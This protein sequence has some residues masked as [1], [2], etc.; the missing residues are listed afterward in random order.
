MK[1]WIADQFPTDKPAFLFDEIERDSR[2]EVSIEAF[3]ALQADRDHLKTRI[4]KAANIYHAQKKELETIKEERDTLKSQADAI[5]TPGGRSETTYLNIIG[6]LLDLIL[7]I[8]PAGRPQSVFD[9]QTAVISALLAH[10]KGKPGISQRTLET[11]FA[12]AK[13]S[14]ISD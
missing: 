9:N 3:L 5:G 1:S 4:E 12:D 10:H 6:G 8:S 14:L 11:K 2:P 13:R 7:G